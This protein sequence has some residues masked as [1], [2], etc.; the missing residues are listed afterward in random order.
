MSVMQY[1]R[2]RVMDRDLNSIDPNDGEETVQRGNP[3][4]LCGKLFQQWTC[5]CYARVDSENLNYIRTH[6]K[7][8]RADSY[9]KV[10]RRVAENTAGSAK[11]VVLPSSYT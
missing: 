11:P 10:Q 7:E 4:H 8:L 9:A 6:Q 3:L 5:D 2:Y 1:W